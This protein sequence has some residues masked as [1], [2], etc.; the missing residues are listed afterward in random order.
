MTIWDYVRAL[1][2]R[3]IGGENFAEKSVQSNTIVRKFHWE[4]LYRIVGNGIDWVWFGSARTE[5]A[6]HARQW[7]QLASC[8]EP[9]HAV[10]ERSNNRVILVYHLLQKRKMDY[11]R[12][13]PFFG[14]TCNTAAVPLPFIHACS[15]SALNCQRRQN[16]PELPSNNSTYDE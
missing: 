2:R 12:Q 4:Q 8:S 3:E 9:V 16:H 7:H 6:Q 5:P 15:T 1:Q 11:V 13:F 10:S 14:V